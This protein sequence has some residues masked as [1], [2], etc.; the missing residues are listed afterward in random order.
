MFNPRPTWLEIDLDAV[1]TNTGLL[2][3]LVGDKTQI[4]AVVKANA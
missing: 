4:M 3:S 2:K 1:A